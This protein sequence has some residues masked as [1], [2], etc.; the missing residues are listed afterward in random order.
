[1]VAIQALIDLGIPMDTSE[2]PGGGL[3]VENGR[4]SKTFSGIPELGA[5]LREAGQSQVEVQRYKGLGEMNPD[6]L[7]ESTMDPEHR[8]LKRIIL[9]DAYEADRIF[10]MLMG[11][12]TEPRR[13]YIE[14]HAHE[15]ENLDI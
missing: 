9:E 5:V 3:C 13:N 7:W 10:S 12:E 4:F 8:T 1:M 11:D 14:E 6:Q 2:I 15:I